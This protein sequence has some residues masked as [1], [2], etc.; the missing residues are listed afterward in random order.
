ME[1]SLQR[2]E[3]DSRRVKAEQHLSRHSMGLLQEGS[4]PLFELVVD[5]MDIED[6]RLAVGKHK[7]SLQTKSDQ[8][9]SI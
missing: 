4:S 5:H 7:A 9:R 3:V 8:S 6:Q 2:L 1:I